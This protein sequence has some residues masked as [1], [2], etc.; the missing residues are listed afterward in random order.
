MVEHSD[1]SKC[2]GLLSAAACPLI[3]VYLVVFIDRT[4]HSNHF[5][6]NLLILHTKSPLRDLIHQLLIVCPS[7]DFFPS[8]TLVWHVEEPCYC[9]RPLPPHLNPSTS[10]HVGCASAEGG[11]TPHFYCYQSPCH[12]RSAGSPSVLLCI[13]ERIYQFREEKH[14]KKKA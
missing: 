11:L 9:I 3:S 1:S 14:E 4:V 2:P 12:L 7:L 8:R 5:R 6:S 13:F 10:R